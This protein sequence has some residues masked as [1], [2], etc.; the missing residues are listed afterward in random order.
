MLDAVVLVANS[1]WSV[2]LDLPTFA[3]SHL[4]TLALQL[5]PAMSS[6]IHMCPACV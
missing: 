6:L 5:A 3:A 4:A 2:Q 1:L